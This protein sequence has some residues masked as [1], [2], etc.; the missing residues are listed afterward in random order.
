MAQISILSAAYVELPFL[1]RLQI[2]EGFFT[3]ELHA[4][5]LHVDMEFEELCRVSKVGTHDRP[6]L[7]KLV[8]NFNITSVHLEELERFGQLALLL[9]KDLCIE[10]LV[11]LSI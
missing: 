7:Q 3:C 5:D 9:N 11:E 6:L 2:F 10:D 8:L 4:L 1:L